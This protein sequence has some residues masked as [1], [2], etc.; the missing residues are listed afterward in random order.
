[1]HRDRIELWILLVGSVMI[2]AYASSL[3]KPMAMMAAILFA[4]LAG[5]AVLAL[6]F[7]WGKRRV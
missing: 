4:G 7:G 5:Y 2:A 3:G 6:V 1:M